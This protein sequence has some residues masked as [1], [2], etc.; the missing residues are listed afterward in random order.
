MSVC[1]VGS[2]RERTRSRLDG[3][4]STLSASWCQFEMLSSFS[5]NEKLA[6]LSLLLVCFI[7]LSSCCTYYTELNKVHC[8]K[9]RE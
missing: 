3:V 7:P 4:V 8:M 6:W 2:L 9:S 1:R 5:W